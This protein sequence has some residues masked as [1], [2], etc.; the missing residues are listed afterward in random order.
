MDLPGV[1][2]PLFF[3]FAVG[4]PIGGAAA[5]SD[6]D[7]CHEEPCSPSPGGIGGTG[8]TAGGSSGASGGGGTA[9]SNDAAAD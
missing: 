8:G 4:F 1:I 5:C 3:V 7:H 9:G 2:R 6:D